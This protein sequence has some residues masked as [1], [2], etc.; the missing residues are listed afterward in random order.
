MIQ[1]AMA[2]SF[3]VRDQS[4]STLSTPVAQQQQ[5]DSRYTYSHMAYLFVAG[6]LYQ[7]RTCWSDDALPLAMTTLYH[8]LFFLI[9]SMTTCTL[10]MARQ[11]YMPPTQTQQGSSSWARALPHLSCS[12]SDEGFCKTIILTVTRSHRNSHS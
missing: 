2:S 9:R 6:I 7:T 12:L 8:I 3:V 10:S 1:L 4:M 11:S 5:L